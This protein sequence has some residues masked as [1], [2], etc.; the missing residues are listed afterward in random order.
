MVDMKLE[1]THALEAGLPSAMAPINAINHIAKRIIG[2]NKPPLAGPFI[3]WNTEY[4]S[5]VS[6]TPGVGKN[7][8]LYSLHYFVKLFNCH[9]VYL[10]L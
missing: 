8:K 5:L 9:F 6:F 7:A 3:N 10:K 4:K 1:K 2:K